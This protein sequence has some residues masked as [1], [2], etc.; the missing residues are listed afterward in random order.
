MYR[1]TGH[2][3]VG[4]SM[5]KSGNIATKEMFKCRHVLGVLISFITYVILQEALMS[6][7]GPLWRVCQDA[8]EGL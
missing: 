6:L 1:G 3:R 4:N 5:N 2:R 8:T 7:S